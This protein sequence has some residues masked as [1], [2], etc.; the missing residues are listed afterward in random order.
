MFPVRRRRC[1]L[2]LLLSFAAIVLLPLSS[3]QIGHHGSDAT[4]LSDL[5]GQAILSLASSHIRL[6]AELPIAVYSLT[7]QTVAPKE[8]RVYF[9]ESE[10]HDIQRRASLGLLDSTNRRGDDVGLQDRPLSKHLLHPVVKF[11]FTED[12][13]QQPSLCQSS[14]NYSLKQ[15]EESWI[16]QSSYWVS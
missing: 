5:Y 3:F 7:R 11:F 8:I 4:T 13:A 9:P 2:L 6:D 14:M 15:T 10:K 1:I 16:G 12:V